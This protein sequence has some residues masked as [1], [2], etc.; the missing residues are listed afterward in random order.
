MHGAEIMQ[1]WYRP[2]DSDFHKLY[3]EW[4]GKA[5]IRQV[6]ATLAKCRGHLRFDFEA[7]EAAHAAM[8][9]ASDKDAPDAPVKKKT[10]RKTA[11]RKTTKDA[12]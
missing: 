5:D 3:S 1:A 9:G 11:T 10:T 8:T 6:Q 2:T 7:I 12:D 4:V